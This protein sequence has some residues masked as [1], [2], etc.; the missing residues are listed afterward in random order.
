MSRYHLVALAASLAILANVSLGCGILKDAAEKVIEDEAGCTDQQLG[1][2]NEPE[3]P[4][5][6]KAVACCKFVK[7]ECGEVKLFT[8]PDGVIQACNV[9]ETVLAN[10]IEEY[11]G[12]TDG[13]CPDYLTEE[14]CQE[15]LAK[16]KENYRKTVDGGDLTMAGANAPSC[17]L[18]VDE[19]VNRLTEQ[20]GAT[21]S[22]LPAACEPVD[23]NLPSPGVTDIVTPGDATFDE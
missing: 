11:Q 1:N 19:T 2:L 5:C 6:S 23:V 14:A 9:N 22:L 18:I 8:A 13:T 7:G 16:T 4:N 10:I 17:Q 3:L 20:L 12:L 21:A 15:G